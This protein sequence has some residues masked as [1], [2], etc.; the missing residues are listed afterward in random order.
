M[1]YCTGNRIWNRPRWGFGQG[2]GYGQGMAFGRR[3]FAGPVDRP[4]RYWGDRS[5]GELQLLN[6][7]ARYLEDELN[8]TRKEIDRLKSLSSNN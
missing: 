8:D 5:S 7:R 4:Y 3:G 1:G 6:E 2:Y